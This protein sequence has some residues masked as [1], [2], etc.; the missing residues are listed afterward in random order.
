MTY[1]MMLVDDEALIVEGLMKVIRW[2]E[3]GFR[4]AATAS[5]GREALSLLE[6]GPFDL[7]ITDVRMPHMD[8]IAL[9]QAIAERRARTKTIIISGYSD[10]E[11]AR[12]ALQF[13]ASGYLLKPTEHHELYA[14]LRKVKRELDDACS[15]QDSVRH[16]EFEAALRELILYNRAGA[17]EEAR[18]LVHVKD[19]G[20]ALIKDYDEE[21]AALFNSTVQEAVDQLVSDLGLTGSGCRLTT[22]K[23]D[24]CV[25]LFAACACGA[26]DTRKFAHRILHHIRVKGVIFSHQPCVFAAVSET[27]DKLEQSHDRYKRL[28]ACLPYTFYAA[29][30]ILPAHASDAGDAG[31]VADTAHSADIPNAEL[32]GEVVNRILL[33]EKAEVVTEAVEHYVRHLRRRSLT[34]AQIRADARKLLNLFRDEVAGHTAE[35]DRGDAAHDQT[36]ERIFTFEQLETALNRSMSERFRFL[37]EHHVHYFTR[38]LH[39]VRKYVDEHYRENI[40]LED[41][42]KAVSLSVS[43]FCFVFKKETGITFMDYLTNYR[44]EKAKQLLLETDLKVY[45]VAEQVG[46]FDVRHFTKQFKRKFGM[47]PVELRKKT[48]TA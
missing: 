31:S 3:F 38:M 18:R 33:G 35:V 26:C 29:E 30:G 16:A 9:I 32:H 43:Y 22:L 37:Q 10:F 45:E 46:Y 4:V 12:Q 5:N 8:G 14:M 25:I 1:R 24:G 48:A 28:R 17:A 21:N 47:K 20:L 44:L 39:L 34:D 27:Y 23:S 13:G 6:E 36:L 15:L 42:V 7:V 2:E 19:Y 41:V 11:Y 40:R